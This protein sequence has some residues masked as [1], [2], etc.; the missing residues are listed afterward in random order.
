MGT[1]TIAAANAARDSR[2]GD[3]NVRHS[4]PWLLAARVDQGVDTI[5]RYG[6]SSQVHYH[7]RKT[8]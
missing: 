2:K 1:C 8:R 6:G 3:P 4:M 5:A 7:P